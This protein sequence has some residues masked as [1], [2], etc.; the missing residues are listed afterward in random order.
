MTDQLGRPLRDLRIS[1]MDN[2]NFRCSYCMPRQL[3]P[4]DY[5]F[6]QAQDLLS[7]AEIRLLAQAFASLGL[8]KIKLTGGEP[9]LRPLLPELVAGLKADLPGVELD[10]ITNGSH[11]KPL[12]GRLQTAGLDR[13]NLSLDSLNQ[14]TFGRLAGKGPSLPVILEAIEATGQAGFS[15]VKINMVVIRGQNDHEIEAMAEYF[16]RPGYV[17]RFIEYMDVGTMNGW[18][19]DQV[20][21][22]AEIAER[23]QRLGRLVPVS[24]AFPGETADRWAWA[25]GTTEVGFISSVTRPFCGDCSRARLGADGKLYTCLFSSRGWDLKTPLRQGAGAADL[26]VLIRDIWEGRQDQYSALRAQAEPAPAAKK[27]EMFYIGG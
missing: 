5:P 17:L 6:L 27:V 13:I 19:R 20:V 18:T 22:S 7:F 15:P 8:E 21:P 25:D 1:V 2:C 23:L 3:F 24:K 12:L 26:A 10:L 16:R 14:E 4:D 11:L 9:L